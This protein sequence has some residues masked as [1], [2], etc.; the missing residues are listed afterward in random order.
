[1]KSILTVACLFLTL[2]IH[3]AGVDRG[4]ERDSRLQFRNDRAKVFAEYRFMSSL[5]LTSRKDYYGNL[6]PSMKTDLWTM[7]LD[8]FLKN[9]QDL[10]AGQKSVIY[11][12]MGL[13]S[14]DL[15]EDKDLQKDVKDELDAQIA[16]NFTRAMQAMIFREIGSHETIY[17]GVRASARGVHALIDD[18][19]CTQE[20]DW[21]NDLTNPNYMCGNVRCVL[22]YGCGTLWLY[23]CDGICQ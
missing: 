7:H 17:S 22:H 9:H 14:A 2:G 19:D 23:T 4:S 3:A 16:A 1:M 20:H 6:T 15:V 5:D 18:C 13:L 10:T 12:A 11:Y 8:T 21:C